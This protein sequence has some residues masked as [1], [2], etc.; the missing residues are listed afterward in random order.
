MTEDQ[1]RFVYKKVN[2]GKGINAET[3]KQEMEQQKSIQT[4]IDDSGDNAYQKAILNEVDKK[5]KVST[6]MEKLSILS[7]HVKYVKHD[8]GTETF[9]KLNVNVLDYHQNKDLY[10]E[11]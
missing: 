10:Q 8:N 1:A 3:M 7:D 5:E 11:L 9:H 4:D 6:Q 2:V